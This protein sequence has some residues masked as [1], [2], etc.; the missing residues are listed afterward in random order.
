MIYGFRSVNGNFVNQYYIIYIQIGTVIDNI[1]ARAMS[2][3]A[4]F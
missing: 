3:F 2:K 4:E 1:F